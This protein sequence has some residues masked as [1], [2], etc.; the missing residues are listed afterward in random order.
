MYKRRRTSRKRRT[1]GRRSYRKRRTATMSLKRAVNAIIT[2]RAETKHTPAP[3]STYEWDISLPT[4]PNK[5]MS[6]PVDL[7]DQYLK[8]SQGTQ[9]GQRVGD[10]IRTKSAKL[11]ILVTPNPSTGQPVICQIFV[12]Y[13]KV[14][15]GTSPSAANLTKIFEEGGGTAEADGTLV[16]LMRNINRELF[17]IVAYRQVK[18]GSQILNGA[19]GV[20]GIDYPAYQRLSIDLTKTLGELQYS[21]SGQPPTNKHL[22]MFCNYVRADGLDV[23]NIVQSPV[24]TYFID[25]KYIDV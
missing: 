24:V 4:Q 14:L 8:I 15:P 5:T 19:Q 11:K 10:R 16:S 13:L 12:G 23:Q 17:H 21:V 2:R 6:D 1:K 7:L 22:Y 9:D 18:V 3:P 20:A 25:Y